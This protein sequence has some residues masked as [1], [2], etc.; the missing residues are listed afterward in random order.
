MFHSILNVILAICLS[1]TVSIDFELPLNGHGLGSDDRNI[2]MV[3]GRIVDIIHG[4]NSPPRLFY[5]RL[6]R[7][8]GFCGGTIISARWVLT[9][10][11]CVFQLR[12]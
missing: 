7:I 3:N 8:S 4:F 10:G 1:K 2:S 5:V 6:K 9:S 11:H 12:R